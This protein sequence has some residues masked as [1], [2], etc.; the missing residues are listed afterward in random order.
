MSIKLITNFFLLNEKKAHHSL[1][2]IGLIFEKI[3][4]QKSNNEVLVDSYMIIRI[5]SYSDH[6]LKKMKKMKS[7]N[8][9]RTHLILLI[10]IFCLNK[11]LGQNPILIDFSYNE[12]E[13]LTQVTTNQG[14]TIIYQYD[15]VGNITQMETRLS[16]IIINTRI[17]L[18]AAY[19]SGNVSMNN[20]LKDILP[21]IEPYTAIGYNHVNGGGGESCSASV[22]T[23][24]SNNGIV[25]WVVIEI[26]D[27]NSPATIFA[28][29][30]ALLQKDGDIV[31]MD[32]K[33]PV[34]IKSVN[35]GMY[36]VAIRHRNHLGIM[37]DNPLALSGRIDSEGVDF[38]NSSTSTWGVNAQ[39]EISGKMVMWQGDA[40]GDGAIKYNGA[41]NDKNAILFQVGLFTPNNIISG[42]YRE[43]ANMDGS[44]KYNGA[45]NDK[46]AILFNVGLFTPNNIIVEQLP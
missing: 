2:K 36:Y 5:K 35:A 28:T 16:G 11:S 26:R 41:S 22:F 31:G 30:S 4:F 40:N 38:T 7:S 45:S 32:G 34:N 21:T 39:K 24:N 10:V 25:D 23:D 6:Y 20:N 12:L 44:I 14:D 3:R 19:N 37:T 17:Y 27:A 33:S 46:N 9:S 42:Y 43:D 1:T 29:H 8:F 13:R 15:E 18:Q